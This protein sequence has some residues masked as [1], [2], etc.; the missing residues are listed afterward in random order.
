MGELHMK[1]LVL[2]MILLLS[3]VALAKT[4]DVNLNEVSIGNQEALSF[5][6]GSATNTI[7][8]SDSSKGGSIKKCPAAQ[9]D[10]GW[11]VGAPSDG[12][13]VILHTTDGGKNWTRQGS[14]QTIPNIP[15][16]DVRAIDASNAW[17]VGDA[18]SNYA[19]ILKTVDGGKTWI[20]CGSPESVTDFGA[21]GIGAVDS[22]V[23]WVVGFN[24]TIIFTEDGGKTWVQQASN[25]NAPLYKMAVVDRCNAWII[26]DIDNG[27]AIILRTSDGGRTWTRQGNASNVKAWG[28]ID[29]TA[30]NNRTAWVVGVDQTVLKTVDGGAS[31]QTQMHTA[32]AFDHMNG[33]CAI[34]ECNAWIAQ[35][36]GVVYWTSDGG[37]TWN[38]QTAVVAKY[39]LMSVS[40]KNLKKAWVVGRS[41]I[42][43][44][45]G[46]ILH[47]TNGGI[48]WTVQFAPVNVPFYRV[49]FVGTIM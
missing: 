26:G 44:R 47:T 30:A 7:Q 38:E 28:L 33:A 3:V 16:N 39:H 17:A 15:I 43:N 20:R 22:K 40:A 18:D 37:K 49:S 41:Q 27:Y 8:I 11:I 46:T 32:G 9:G 4:S 42:D 48:N 24:G 14:P 5:A 13:G 21:V 1:V 31:W 2:L 36:D 45:V 10:I 35:D 29:A 19:T 23:A 6:H 12:Y 25:K 34:D